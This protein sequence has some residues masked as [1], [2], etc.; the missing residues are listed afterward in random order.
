MERKKVLLIKLSSLGDVIFN[1]PLAYALKDAGYE[2]SWLVSEKGYDII[3]NNPCVDKAILAPI[4][5]WR[6][7]GFSIRNIVE[8]WSLIRQLRAEKYDIS[9]DAQMMFKSLFFNMLCGARRR[10]TSKK[11]KEFAVLGANELVEGISYSPNCSIVLNYLKFAEYLGINTAEIKTSLPNRTKE[12]VLKINELLKD[13]DL[14][15]PTVI[16]A[17]ATTWENKHWDIENWKMVVN[18]LSESA[19]IVFSGG[20]KDEELVEKINN[21]RF[22]NLAGKT[23]LMELIELF[24]RADVVISPDSGSAHLA[25]A[26]NK[27]AVITIFTCTPE[28][29]LA[30]I[31]DEGKYIA[32][33]GELS[34]RPCFKKKCKLRNDKNL[35]TKLPEPEEVVEVANKIFSNKK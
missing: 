2:V 29:V 25:W 18:K 34:C 3:K 27:P 4:F 22:L 12:V 15:K 30:P 20:E 6:K 19:S 16:V 13:I 26:L 1:I 28:K 8:F 9:I 21:K 17:P 32:V 35:C 10:I 33:S 7:R 14:S 31:G 24:S 5:S 11:A 23:N